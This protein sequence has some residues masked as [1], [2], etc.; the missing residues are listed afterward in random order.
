MQGN[1]RISAPWGPEAA[2]AMTGA[3]GNL[4]ELARS[5]FPAESAAPFIET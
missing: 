1:P 2:E 4:F 3:T 5:R